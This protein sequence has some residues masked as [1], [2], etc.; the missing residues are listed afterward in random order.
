MPFMER[1]PR[2]VGAV[3]PICMQDGERNK[4]VSPDRTN[5]EISHTQGCCTFKSESVHKTGSI[6]P[7]IIDL[8]YVR[9]DQNR[10]CD[11]ASYLQRLSYSFCI[12]R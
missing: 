4:V 12:T 8:S 2:A 5:T 1:S 7:I 9:Q 3:S 6:R 11:L 10:S